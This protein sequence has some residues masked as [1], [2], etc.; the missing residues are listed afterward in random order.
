PNNYNSPLVDNLYRNKGDGTFEDATEISG[1]SKIFG[2]GLG[3][4]CADYNNDGRSDVLMQRA[5]PGD[6]FLLLADASGRLMGISQTIG[7]AHVG[8]TWSKDQHTLLPGDLSGDGFDDLFFQAAEPAGTHGIPLANS[9]GLF[10]SSPTQTFTDAS[11]PIFKWSRKHAVISTGDFN[12]DD[13]LDLLIQTKPSLVLIDYDIPIPVPVYPPNSF[14]IV[15]SQGGTTPLQ[16]AG[17]QQWN[18][19][20]NGVDWSPA[21]SVPIVGDFNGDGRDD[22]LLQLARRV[23]PAIC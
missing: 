9:S 5:T 22:V 14:G 16:L 13:K 17:V 20:H 2:N 12:G 7:Q 15:Y 8:L 19:L 21:S 6:S 4:A 11:F 3:I 1:I 23:G 10:T 18:R